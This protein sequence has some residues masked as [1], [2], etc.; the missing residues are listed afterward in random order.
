MRDSL[1]ACDLTS[2]LLLPC[3][4]I[5]MAFARTRLR[6]LATLKSQLSSRCSLFIRVRGNSIFVGFLGDLCHTRRQ[7][8]VCTPSPKNG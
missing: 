5:L 3:F 2:A 6:S 4:V 1:E 8:S 7:G